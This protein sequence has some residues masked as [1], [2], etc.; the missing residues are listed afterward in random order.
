MG[1][2][3]THSRKLATDPGNGRLDSWK[4]IAAY[5]G[6][7]VRT[8]QRW[9]EQ[10]GLPVHRLPHADR[11]SVFA[12]PHELDGWRA[13]RS[14]LPEGHSDDA[15]VNGAPTPQAFPP[16]PSSA[17][18]A[19]PGRPRRWLFA[20]FAAAVVLAATGLVAFFT[21]SAPS[22][23][24]L[25]YTQ[26]THDGRWKDALATDGVWVYFLDQG[27]SGIELCK[28]SIFGG[29]ITRVPL[30]LPLASTIAVSPDGAKL[31]IGE[32]GWF[33]RESNAWVF[34]TSGKP[35]HRMAG[36]ITGYFAWTPAKKIVYARG[37]AI[38]TC[39][40]DG[41]HQAQVLKISDY[42]ARVGWSPDARHIWYTT[43]GSPVSFGEVDAD[44]GSPRRV[45]EENG[46]GGAFCTGFWSASGA[47]LGFIS[48]S[49]HLTTLRVA[50]D[51]WSWFARSR[52]VSSMVFSLPE[53]IGFAPDIAHNRLLV[54]AAGP[55]YGDVFRFDPTK[56]Q[57]IPYFDGVSAHDIDFS[58]DGRSAAYVDSYDGTLWRYDLANR[59]KTRLTNPPLFVQLPRFSPDGK[60]IA[61]S[62]TGPDGRSKIYRL[63]AQ[64]GSLERLVAGDENEGAPT[65]SPDGKSLIFGKVDCVSTGQC[66]VFRYDFAVHSLRMLPGSHEFRTARWSP[67]GKYVAALRAADQSL[68]LFDFATQHWKKIYSPVWGD[69]LSWSHNAKYVY[70]YDDRRDN[71][72][73]F[74]VSVPAGTMERVASLK[75]LG[76]SGKKPFPWFGLAL[77]DSPIVSRETGENEIFSVSYQMP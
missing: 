4:E 63:P 27:N 54:L 9:E 5:L 49:S 34:S 2:R 23:Q 59:Q 75:S 12:F 47:S 32:T 55:W 33:N 41:T 43:L 30:D 51:S 53:V 31:L 6:R 20:V 1:E 56:G 28:V 77:D 16:N 17:S 72:V 52:T 57:F 60:W 70:A 45:L 46:T 69:I 61:L 8:V 21:G 74:R 26:V 14:H 36:G 13:S 22:V 29:E 10:E 7:S 66:G 50:P 42:V 39:D 68:M 25:N 24:I 73:I 71:P 76:H 35:L 38:W 64:G 67:D 11:S 48:S 40:E 58:P 19:R 65:W 15:E 18:V 62:G 3:E 37:L 44:G